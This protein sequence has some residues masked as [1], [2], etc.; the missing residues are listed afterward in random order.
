MVD[1]MT[2]AW[3]EGVAPERKFYGAMEAAL[4]EVRPW[5]CELPT[6]TNFP[7]PSLPSPPPPPSRANAAATPGYDESS[8]EAQLVSLPVSVLRSMLTPPK[9]EITAKRESKEEDDSTN[10]TSH[11]KNPSPDILINDGVRNICSSDSFSQFT[12]NDVLIPSTDKDMFGG[13]SF[14]ELTPPVMKFDDDCMA[15]IS[16]VP[17]VDEHQVMSSSFLDDLGDLSIWP[18]VDGFFSNVSDLF[19]VEPLPAL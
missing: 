2:E 5:L 13:I 15:C 6:T 19:T 9:V 14:G 1:V 11:H 4:G 8:D 16:H 12:S 3:G 17:S 18:E 10:H 7:V